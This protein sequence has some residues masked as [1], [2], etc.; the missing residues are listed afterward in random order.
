VEWYYSLISEFKG[1]PRKAYGYGCG[2]V[3]RY[4]LTD[5]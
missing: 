4:G 3:D 1:Q 5:A 2:I